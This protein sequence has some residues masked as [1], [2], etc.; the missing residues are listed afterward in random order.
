MEATVIIIF[1][2]G[3]LLIALEH[4]IKVNKSATAIVTGVVCWTIYA[5]FSG[6]SAEHVTH[7]LAEHF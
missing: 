1:I 2:I 3:Y 6:N 4:P 7:Q 5:L